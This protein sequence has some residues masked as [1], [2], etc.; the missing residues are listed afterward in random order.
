MPKQFEVGVETKVF[1]SAAGV[2]LYLSAGSPDKNNSWVIIID[3]LCCHVL[4]CLL[5]FLPLCK[6]K[7]C[8]FNSFSSI[9]RE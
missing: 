1:I 6:N 7:S 9:M 3:T 2:S 5:S 8:F 4:Q